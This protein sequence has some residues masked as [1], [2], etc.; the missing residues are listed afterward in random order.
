MAIMKHL[1]LVDVGIG[2]LMI[3]L[4][5]PLALQKIK[6]NM[7]YGFRTPRTLSDEGIW[8]A[9]NQYAG[10][11]L[12]IAGS[13]MVAGAL[14]L[15]WVAGSAEYRAILSDP[16]VF[17]LWLVVLSVPLAVCII[18]SFMYLRSL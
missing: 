2:I 4:A 9:A 5:V 11:A 16:L 3:V 7:W 17:I 18:A 1:F 8:Y 14:V 13:V 15:Y 10:K 12:L 6:P